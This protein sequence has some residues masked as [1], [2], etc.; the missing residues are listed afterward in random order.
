MRKQSDLRSTD[1]GGA[2]GPKDESDVATS[3]G[4]GEPTVPQDG[5]SAPE[6]ATEP[7]IDA[8]D[9]GRSETLDPDLRT[10]GETTA[11]GGN[12]SALDY[13]ASSARA[14]VAGRL[15]PYVVLER[16]G[17]GGMGIVLKALDERLGRIVAIK[18]LSPSLASSTLARRRFEREARAA[19]AVCHEHVVT[20]HAVDQ[21]AGRPY[22][23]MQFVAGQSLQEKLDR[24][25]SLD[26][27]EVIRIGM[28]VASGLAAA[29]GQGLIHRDIKPANLLLE[30]GGERVKITD[31]G[32]AR[33]IDDASITESGVVLGTPHYMSPEQ[34]R[35]DPVDHRTDLFS[36][37]S[38]LYAVCTG[39]PPFRADSTMAVLRKVCDDAAQSIRELNPDVPEWLAAIIVKLMSKD[40]D[41]RYHS[42]SEVAELLTRHLA[43]LQQPT[44][45][46]P[47][48]PIAA[49]AREEHG[50]RLGGPQL[51]MLCGLVVMTVGITFWLALRSRG[52]SSATVNTATLALRQ[53]EPTAAAALPP[54]RPPAPPV[55]PTAVAA[56][57]VARA[58]VTAEA[59]KNSLAFNEQGAHAARQGELDKAIESYSEA[60]RLDP[61][62]TRALLERARLRA[63]YRV[64]N[65]PGAIADATEVIRRDAKNAEAFETRASA[66]TFAGDHRRAIEDASEAIRLDPDRVNAYADRGGAYKALGEWKHA[67]VDLNEFLSRVPNSSWQL[68]TRAGVHFSLGDDDRA[69]ADMN[70]AIELEPRVNHFWI[71]RG[72]VF[73]RKKN[74]DHA[75]ADLT[76]AIRVSSESEKYFAYQRRGEFAMMLSD[77]EPAIA[78]F[79]E[80]IRRN[81]TMAETKDVSGYGGRAHAYLARGETDRAL[82]DCEE[83]LRISPKATW[84]LGRRGFA[85]AR[86]GQWD[87][88]VADFDEEAKRQPQARTNWLSTKASALALA[89]RYDEAAATFDL[90]REHAEASLR[91]IFSC[92]GYYLDRS[93]G[94]FDQAIKNLNLA[95]DPVWPPNAY[96]Y[97]GIIYARLGQSDQ[98]L[99]DF[100]K[101]MDIVEDRRRDFFGLEDFVVRRLVF[102][103]GR[104]EAYLIKGDLEHALT[105]AD[106]AVRI[107][108]SSA[109]ARLLRARVYDRQGMSG[110]A[111][112]DRRAAAK[113]VPDPIVAAP[114]ARR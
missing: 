77:L 57:S 28:Q 50:L 48:E 81:R 92:R 31:F 63:N 82:A 79:T 25:G 73:A 8:I 54:Y 49:I 60:F 46:V 52:P 12:E 91:G 71:F 103:L 62:N 26:I 105:D 86:K 85:L 23:V 4:Q 72:Q 106:Q 95:E 70:R 33:A 1:S 111:D 42:A 89:G 90:A 13:V 30:T 45:T 35:G 97:R 55:T 2:A 65:W 113:L 75:K 9:A 15:G 41:A 96:L 112:G 88:A 20:I 99:A 38:V 69:L 108:P 37:G 53:P 109:E 80:T 18:M 110:L 61:S 6:F 44:P 17:K 40:V 22:L 84:I 107:A 14:G 68:F 7:R 76:E 39:Q 24:D 101:L 5:D 100:K 19:A 43:Q 67:I 11:P 78:D 74:Y 56:A 16:I 21:D 64:K 32:L 47:I 27:E 114:I 102:L 36:L 3:Q 83:A 34:A 93:R 66:E 87:R 59:A 58:T 98:A 51:L 29:H 104:G 94:D 10:D